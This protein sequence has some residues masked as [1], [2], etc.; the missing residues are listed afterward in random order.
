M[1]SSQENFIDLG[2]N[3]EVGGVIPTVSELL[4]RSFTD[5]VFEGENMYFCEKCAS[6]VER[7]VK[8]QR[9]DTVPKY[10][11][12]TLNRFYFDRATLKKCKLLNPVQVPIEME[13][14]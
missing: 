4:L 1:T 13:I 14:P 12:L 11:I 7:A 8:R 9:L 10:L 6:K 5:E 2:L 3:F